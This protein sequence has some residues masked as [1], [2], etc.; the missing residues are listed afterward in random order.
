[1]LILTE[2]WK[3][4]DEPAAESCLL[5]RTS[6]GLCQVPDFTGAQDAFAVMF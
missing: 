3:M 2:K 4:S 6:A 1:M 5:E